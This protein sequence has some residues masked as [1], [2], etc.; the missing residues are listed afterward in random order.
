M[1]LRHLAGRPANEANSVVALGYTV[2]DLSATYRLGNYQL[3]V[4]LENLTDTET[5]NGMKPNSTPNHACAARPRRFPNCILR[6][7]I[8]EMCAWG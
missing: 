7:A 3:Q 5:R 2:L 6:R 4:V 8:P 1:R